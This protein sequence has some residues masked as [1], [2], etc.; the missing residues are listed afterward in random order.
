MSANLKHSNLNAS[1]ASSFYGLKKNSKSTPSE[2]LGV[3][4][5]PDICLVKSANC[6]ERQEEPPRKKPKLCD[7][8]GNDEADDEEKILRL[9]L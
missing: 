3:K 1:N 5:S 8:L 6:N 4:E 9:Y 2:P 7:K